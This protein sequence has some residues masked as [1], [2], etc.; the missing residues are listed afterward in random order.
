M[1]RA[2]FALSRNI[3][4]VISRKTLWFLAL[5]LLA[6]LGVTWWADSYPA[7]IVVINQGV[8]VRDL[9]IKTTGQE[10]AIGA[11]H[12]AETRIV[13]V[14]SGDYITIE[15]DASQHRTWQ[16]PDKASPAQSMTVV[17]RANERVDWNP[18]RP[19]VP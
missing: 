5:A 11:L 16:S 12:A 9:K 8:A 17:I 10:L 3:F 6:V 1:D 4:T 13:K 2:H 18:Q 7:R 14:P 19:R 15:F